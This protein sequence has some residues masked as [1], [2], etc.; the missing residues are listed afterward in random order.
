MGAL[1]NDCR[2]ILTTWS[3]ECPTTL[4]AASTGAQ[5]WLQVPQRQGGKG[6]SG[7][8]HG[9][10][11]GPC[12]GARA[13]ASFSTTSHDCKTSLT[14]ISTWPRPQT[15]I[16]ERDCVW[17]ACVS[18][19]HGRTV[20]LSTSPPETSSDVFLFVLGSCR[21]GRHADTLGLADDRQ[22]SFFHMH[23][24]IHRW[25]LV[26]TKHSQNVRTRGGYL[27]IYGCY[28]GRSRGAQGAL[29]AQRALRGALCT[30]APKIGAHSTSLRAKP[31]MSGLYC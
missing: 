1:N 7:G 2:N 5:P 12:L 10:S 26:S 24:E 11:D 25:S 28:N 4:F 31:A 20:W 27:I 9:S 18:C 19:P 6:P 15:W 21:C 29:S 8:G 30:S 23:R 14:R 16:G 13:A 17:C 22:Q 3:T